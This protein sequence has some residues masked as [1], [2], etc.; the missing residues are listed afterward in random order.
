MIGHVNEDKNDIRTVTPLIPGITTYYARHTWATLAYEAG[1]PVD[2]ISQA[3][4]HSMGNKTTLIYIKPDQDK[5]DKAN[6][7]VIDRF[8]TLS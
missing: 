6:R 4:G 2:V 8:F 1:V 7:L 3:L 5:V